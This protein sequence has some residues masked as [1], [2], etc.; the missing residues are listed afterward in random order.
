M[1]M[2]VE[3]LL[4]LSRLDA[5]VDPI[6]K[7]PVNI[8]ELAGQCVDM[9]RPIADQRQISI[10]MDVDDSANML[11]P[12]P[13][14]PAKLREVLV[15]LIDNAVHY[16]K[17]EG[18]VTLRISAAPKSVVLEVIDTGV[19]MSPET[20]SHLFER[21]YR[22]DPSRQSE[23][24]NAG[25]GLAIVKGY[26]DLFGGTISVNSLPGKG[27]TFRVTLPRVMGAVPVYA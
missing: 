22:A 14:D 7:E 10:E 1:T 2:L 20:Q 13:S 27:S 8:V 26:I 15:N 6:R 18:A 12:Q 17:D 23:T 16:N 5:G 3:R 21:F 9:L 24:V 19:G 4:V 25:L 11:E